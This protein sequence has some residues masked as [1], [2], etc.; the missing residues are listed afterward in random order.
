MRRRSFNL[1]SII[2][3]AYLKLVEAT[4]RLEIINHDKIEE[5]TMV[6]YWHGDSYCMQLVLSHISK[7]IQ[8][9]NVIVTADRRG[10]VIEK[11]V[12][13]Y[14]AKALRLPDGLKMRYFLRELKEISKSSPE[15]LAVAL[16]G[17][18]GPIHEPKKLLFLLASEADKKMVYVHF[19]YTH[20][21]RLKYRWDNYVIP[22]PFA[23]IT[24]YVEE[25][26]YISKEDL[27]NFN[28]YKKKLKC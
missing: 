2:F 22:L 27:T 23:R 19:K 11:I 20:V 5:N 15:V 4:G 26:G 25:L 1:L 17:P 13:H 3:L 8:G 7:R 10:D 12:S 9:I 18:L 21:I 24:A 28:D 6:G 16:D 14:G